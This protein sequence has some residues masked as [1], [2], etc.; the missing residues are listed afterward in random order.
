M[1]HLRLAKFCT[2]FPIL[3]LSPCAPQ[4]IV[5]GLPPEPKEVGTFKSTDHIHSSYF[6]LPVAD[7]VTEVL[8][9]SLMTML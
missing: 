3:L 4:R 2:L 9:F 8:D 1:S 6:I 7:I 5:G